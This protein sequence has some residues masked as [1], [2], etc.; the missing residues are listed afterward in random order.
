MSTEKTREGSTVDPSSGATVKSL[1]G[2]TLVGITALTSI[3][4]MADEA[5]VDHN[6]RNNEQRRRSMDR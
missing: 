5:A 6:K 1:S 3:P 2:R 4:E